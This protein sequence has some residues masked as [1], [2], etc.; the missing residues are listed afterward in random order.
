GGSWMISRWLSSAAAKLLWDGTRETPDTDPNDMFIIELLR[1]AI[2][3]TCGY[4]GDK[5]THRVG[6]KLSLTPLFVAI[7]SIGMVDLMFALDS[8]PAIYGITTEPYIVFTTTAF[9]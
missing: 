7:I 6:G 8:I 5:L 9:A 3:V 1:T 4:H 2:P